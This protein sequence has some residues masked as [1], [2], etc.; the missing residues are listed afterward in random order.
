MACGLTCIGDNSYGAKD[1]ITPETGWLCDDVSDYIEVLQEIKSDLSILEK[2][3]KAA[4]E[5]AKAEFV[6][7]KWA[8]CIIGE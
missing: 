5:R 3:G 4:R 2:K 7:T 8:D 6:P 1:R